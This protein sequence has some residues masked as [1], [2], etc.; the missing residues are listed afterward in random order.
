MT[1]FATDQW[2]ML[3]LAFLLG[4]FVGMMF[5]AGGRWK[6]RYRDEV[7][8]REEETRRREAL[9]AERTHWEASRIAADARADRGPGPL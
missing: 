4:L 6:R 3:A 2:V 8:L 7:R 9:E 1:P 5:L